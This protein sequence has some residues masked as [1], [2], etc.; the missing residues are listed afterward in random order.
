VEWPYPYCAGS[1][2]NVVWVR[3]SAAVDVV[4][5]RRSE[6]FV[7]GEYVYEYE[8]DERLFARG[9]GIP[10]PPSARG[11][12]LRD[13]VLDVIRRRGDDCADGCRETT[14]ERVLVG[15]YGPDAPPSAVASIRIELDGLV[16]SGS[17]TEDGD[18]LV[19]CP[20]SGRATRVGDA[21]L[22]DYHDYESRYVRLHGVRIFLRRL[23]VSERVSSEREREYHDEWIR[24]GRPLGM[25]SEL[26]RG[27]TF[28][29][30]HERGTRTDYSPTAEEET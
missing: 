24:E 22:T 13:L 19:W 4:L 3:G 26:P 29:R 16:N 12:S 9:N 8:C 18:L 15:V 10:E 30:P 2:V 21:S 28:V 27:Y 7:I 11:R 25:P 1:R 5:R 17:L 6:P 14:R 20:G 23:S